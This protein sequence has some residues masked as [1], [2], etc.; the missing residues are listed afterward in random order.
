MRKKKF[1]RRILDPRVLRYGA[2]SNN[3][4][5]RTRFLTR[6]TP[7]LHVSNL[8][9]Q[10]IPSSSGRLNSSS[11][12]NKWTAIIIYS[13][14]F[15]YQTTIIII[16][17]FKRKKTP[18]PKHLSNSLSISHLL[19][20]SYPF[21]EKPRQQQPYYTHLTSRFHTDELC[22]INSQLFPRKTDHTAR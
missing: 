4:D 17:R 15:L 10:S 18:Q 19:R 20:N 14:T 3:L 1:P 12:P 6:I 11:Q 21:P 2:I 22:K 13:A 7:I 9:V 5:K 16:I 8:Y